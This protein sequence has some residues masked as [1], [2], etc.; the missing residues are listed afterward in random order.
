M[1]KSASQTLI[2]GKNDK[3]MYLI[4]LFV[5][6]CHTNLS[7]SDKSEMFLVYLEFSHISDIYFQVFYRQIDGGLNSLMETVHLVQ[8]SH[9]VLQLKRGFI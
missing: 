2:G 4:S 5:T 9:N 1:G 3:I 6:F 7:T 8:V